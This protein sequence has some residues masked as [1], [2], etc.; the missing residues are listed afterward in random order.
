M[1]PGGKGTLLQSLSDPLLFHSFGAWD[2]LD[3]IQAMRLDPTAQAALQR[4]SELC[5][6]AMPG[7]FKVVAEG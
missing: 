6:E 3:A 5:T 1:P 2:S 7:T 4:I